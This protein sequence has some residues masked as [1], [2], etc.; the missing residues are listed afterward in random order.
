MSLALRS[1]G[2]GEEDRQTA[3]ELEKVMN[4]FDLFSMYTVQ[5]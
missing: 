4:V 5:V 1:H 2:E 3:D